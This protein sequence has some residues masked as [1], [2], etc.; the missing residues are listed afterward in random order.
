[1]MD[2]GSLV[3]N[4]TLDLLRGKGQQGWRIQLQALLYSGDGFPTTRKAVRL[5]RAASV[6]VASEV[7]PRIGRP[8]K[9]PFISIQGPHIRRH[10]GGQCRAARDEQPEVVTRTKTVSRV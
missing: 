5:N 3:D 10:E 6:V 1:M 7:I 2:V 4:S 9:V 8:L